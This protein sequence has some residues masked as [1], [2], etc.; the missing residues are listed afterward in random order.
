MATEYT[1]TTEEVRK[2]WS[3]YRHEWDGPESFGRNLHPEFDRWYAAE[4]A[5]AEKR[6]AEK[7][8]ARIDAYLDS[9]G[10]DADEAHDGDPFWGGYRQ[11]QRGMIQR[12]SAALRSGEEA[13]Q[14]ETPHFAGD[15]HESRE[16]NKA[17]DRHDER[18]LE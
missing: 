6:G 11:A 9:L 1:P 7:A 13:D 15:L 10:V 16:D 18:G 5:E 8:Q 17:D 4:V 14:P 2:A 3:V 12:A